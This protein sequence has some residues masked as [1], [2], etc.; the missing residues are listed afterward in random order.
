MWLFARSLCET[1]IDR[2]T[3]I[4]ASAMAALSFL[5]RQQGGSI[6]PA[7][8]VYLLLSRRLRFDRAGL[9]LFRQVV[10]IPVVVAAGYDLW[11]GSYQTMAEMQTGFLRE[12]EQGGGDGS[13]W[14]LRWLTVFQLI[15][16]GFFTLPLMVAAIPAL[17]G[18]VQRSARPGG[19]SS[20]SGKP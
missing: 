15:Y 8:I 11:L 6:V 13:W 14:L 3:F 19:S 12:V 9:V 5:A 20:R 17:C 4:A 7:V 16:L 10:A 2:P 18:L 1:E